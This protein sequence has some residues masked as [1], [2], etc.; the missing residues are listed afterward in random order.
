MNYKEQIII[1]VWISIFSLFS[2][3]H[4]PYIRVIFAMN[5]SGCR[6]QSLDW[7][8]HTRICLLAACRIAFP[9]SLNMQVVLTQTLFNALYSLWS[10]NN[11]IFRNKLI[12]WTKLI[13][14][15]DLEFHESIA[16]YIDFGLFGFTFYYRFLWDKMF[17]GDNTAIT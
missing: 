12:V 11:V 9:L 4:T 5:Q 13:V 17:S 2:Q 1:N 15:N 14:R 16:L 6:I 3:F 8:I 7:T 10:S